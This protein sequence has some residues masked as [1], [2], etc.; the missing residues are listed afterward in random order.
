MHI[1]FL[2]SPR[3]EPQLANAQ[4]FYILLL[5][6]FY[7]IQL[8]TCI[9]VYY[10]AATKTLLATFATPFQVAGEVAA[11]I[12]TTKATQHTH[13]KYKNFPVKSLESPKVEQDKLTSWWLSGHQLP[14]AGCRLPTVCCPAGS[15]LLLVQRGEKE[16]T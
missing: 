16:I 14:A 1:N 9:I 10:S 5:L 11:A 6:E 8:F 7:I 13:I 3:C 15:C 12:E 4:E 2:N